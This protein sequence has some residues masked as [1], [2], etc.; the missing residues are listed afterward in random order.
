V[1]VEAVK[2]NFR[3]TMSS[4]ARHKR[5]DYSG[6]IIHNFSLLYPRKYH[7]KSY[8]FFMRRN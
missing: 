1:A 2:R 5:V 8:I 3:A 4:V 6:T 7:K